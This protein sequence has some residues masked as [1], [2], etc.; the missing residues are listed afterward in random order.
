MRYIYCCNLINNEIESPNSPEKP[1]F[2]VMGWD[3]NL[4]C[5]PIE[6]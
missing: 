1:N 2:K 3:T 6:S 5:L 4:G